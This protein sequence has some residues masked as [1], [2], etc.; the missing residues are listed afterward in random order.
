MRKII[1][2][3]GGLIVAA[4]SGGGYDIGQQG[5]DG[6]ESPTAAPFAGQNILRRVPWGRIG[7]ALAGLI[8][9]LISIAA[10]IFALAQASAARDQNVDSERQELISLVAGI[11]QEPQSI[12]QAAATFKTEPLEFRA[13]Q[14]GFQMTEL[15]DAEE[16]ADIISL[17]HG[18]GVTAIEY[19]ETAL[20]LQ[21]GQSDSQALQLLQTAAG[22]KNSDPRTQANVL[23]EEAAIYYELGPAYYSRAEQAD[24]L[25]RAA[26][27]SGPDIPP[28]NR[29]NNIAFTDLFDAFYQSAV[30][31][32]AA[33]A[34]QD[35]GKSLIRDNP[36]IDTSGM[37]SQEQQTEAALEKD[38]CLP[39]VG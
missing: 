22:M 35:A 31:C 26:Y 36:A 2:P 32:P 20:G 10:A 18:N 6:L 25:A 27:D 13:V 33:V 30:S 19:F 11:A 23:H 5:L 7:K 34:E 4:R 37:Q 14:V 28:V 15:A 24:A 8:P 17:L 3:I 12:D 9:V 21:S 38:R 16:A 29:L 39:A 1:V